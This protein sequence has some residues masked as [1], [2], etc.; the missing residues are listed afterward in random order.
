MGLPATAR[1]ALQML[2][3]P[4]MLP[5]MVMSWSHTIRITEGAAWNSTIGPSLQTTSTD[6]LFTAPA[7][8]GVSI[9]FEMCVRLCS[10][11][12]SLDVIYGECTQS[13]YSAV[14]KMDV[15]F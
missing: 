14:R 15:M 6:V 3:L 5:G 11:W 10:R 4:G 8:E 9:V 13:T 12:P 7:C 2:M 1:R